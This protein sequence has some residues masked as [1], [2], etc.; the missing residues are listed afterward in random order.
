MTRLTIRIDFPSGA[1]IGPGKVALLEAIRDNGSIR[2]A[3][4]ALGMS[5]RQ[6]WLLLA[7]IEDLFAEPVMEQVRGGRSGGGSRLTETGIAI[8]AHY[9]LIEATSMEAAR[10]ELDTLEAKLRRIIQKKPPP[11][12]GKITRHERKPLKRKGKRIPLRQK[13]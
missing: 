2:G 5:Y 6:A 8:A 12:A 11:E 1:S 3:A 4:K 13:K 9:R 7:A 10:R